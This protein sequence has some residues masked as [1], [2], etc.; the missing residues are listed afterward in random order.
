MMFA[1]KYEIFRGSL[2]S[3]M[4]LPAHRAGLTGKEQVSLFYFA[5][6]IYADRTYE[7]A[8]RIRTGHKL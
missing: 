4:K 3:D 1:E 6:R 5:G 7:T 2:L 8:C